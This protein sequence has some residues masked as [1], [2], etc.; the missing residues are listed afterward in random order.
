[1]AVA[2]VSA[3]VAFGPTADFVVAGVLL[4]T[5][6]AITAIDLTDS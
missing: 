2:L 5:L 4:A 3:Y 1:M 6:I